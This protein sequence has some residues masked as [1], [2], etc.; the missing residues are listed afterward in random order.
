MCKQFK[1]RKRNLKTKYSKEAIDFTNKLIQRKIKNRLGFNSIA[2][3]KKHVW[4]EDINWKKI[5]NKLYLPPYTP[6]IKKTNCFYNNYKKDN[7]LNIQFGDILS[8]NKIKK[9]FK[10]FFL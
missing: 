8:S 7:Y 1:I 6:T 9:T 4:F 10:D 5:K 3:V 2:D